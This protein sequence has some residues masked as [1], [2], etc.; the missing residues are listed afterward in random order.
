MVPFVSTVFWVVHNAQYMIAIA[1]GL[2]ALFFSVLAYFI[3]RWILPSPF[4][5]LSL[6]FTSSASAPRRT[7]TR[8][9]PSTPKKRDVKPAVVGK[10]TPTTRRRKADVRWWDGVSTSVASAIGAG[11]VLCAVTSALVC[12]FSLTSQ[13]CQTLRQ[14]G[15]IEWLPWKTGLRCYRT[16]WDWMGEIIGEVFLTV[17]RGYQHGE[18]AAKSM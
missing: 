18:V 3:L 17:L 2:T 1:F 4:A 12:A 14:S 8:K 7:S 5:L 11:L 10:R 6:P 15:L 9:A 13:G 16:R